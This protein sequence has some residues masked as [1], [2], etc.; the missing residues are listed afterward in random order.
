MGPTLLSVRR[1]PV[2]NAGWI[3]TEMLVNDAV[4]RLGD[5]LHPEASRV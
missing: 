1:P 4:E 5:D 3:L 2:L